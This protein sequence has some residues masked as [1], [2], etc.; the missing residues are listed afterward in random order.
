MVIRTR[1]LMQLV[2]VADQSLYKVLELRY[3]V[4]SGRT[5][6]ASLGLNVVGP[7]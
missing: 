7:I 6:I 1:G 3:W 2:C 5:V 4:K